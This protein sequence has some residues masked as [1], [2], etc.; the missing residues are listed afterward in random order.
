MVS[1][2]SEFSCFVIEHFE[3]TETSEGFY[4]NI[5]WGIKVVYLISSTFLSI[6]CDFK[7]LLK[8]INEN[9]SLKL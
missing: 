1:S 3:N 9:L 5:F 8:V 4:E 7:I 6:L 2:V